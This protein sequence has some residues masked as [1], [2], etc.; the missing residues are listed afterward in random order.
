R[1]PR[2]LPQG[3]GRGVRRGRQARPWRVAADE[4]QRGRP[5]LHPPR[6]VRHV[7]A[8]R[9]RPPAAGRGGRAPARRPQGRRR[10]R[11]GRRAVDHGHA[12]AR[13]G[14]GA[15]SPANLIEPPVT[16]ASAPFWE[17]TRERRLVLPWSA[18]TGRPV[19]FPRDADP[20]APDRPY[21]WREASGEGVVYA[22]SVH[23]RPGPGRTED[24]CPYV[25]AL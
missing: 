18:V 10:P 15:V 13:H 12:R 16:E 1:G 6:H 17:A 21:E 4:H 9:G 25:V 20:L 2:L 23:H 5:L 8:R 22:A 11:L 3:R 14:G 19:W 7:P 24:D